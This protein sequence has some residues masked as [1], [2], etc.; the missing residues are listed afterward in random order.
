MGQQRQACQ[1]LQ[2]LG[3][4]SLQQSTCSAQHLLARSFK[5]TLGSWP[6]SQ[7]AAATHRGRQLARLCCRQPS[8]Q[9]PA[10]GSVTRQHPACMHGG[11]AAVGRYTGCVQCRYGQGK[12]KKHTSASCRSR[13]QGPQ[14]AL[15]AA[16]Q[17]ACGLLLCRAG[18]LPSSAATCTGLT[19]H[20]HWPDQPQW[21]RGGCFPLDGSRHLYGVVQACGAQRRAGKGGPRCW[22]LMVPGMSGDDSS[23]TR[24]ST[25]RGGEPAGQHSMVRLL[26]TV[27]GLR[28]AGSAGAVA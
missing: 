2:Q 8:A 11:T 25:C 19:S 26:L 4:N 9:R 24:H 16:G 6:G 23:R 5:C 17:A 7:T 3:S 21:Q 18:R 13:W 1:G 22:L 20:L 14:V 27:L 15:S 10:P 12:C 28:V